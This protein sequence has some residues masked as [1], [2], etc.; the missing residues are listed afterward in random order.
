MQALA[1]EDA[2]LY[3][4]RALTIALLRGE[5]DVAEQATL[6]LALAQA[7]F[8]LSDEERSRRAAHACADAAR[9]A[10]SA[11]SAD[12]AQAAILLWL[13]RTFSGGTDA[14][15]E[16]LPLVREALDAI[17][18][19]L[20][21]TR[22]ELLDVLAFSW[23]SASDAS[24]RANVAYS[25]ESLVLARATGDRRL[26]ADSLCRASLRAERSG[27][28]RGLSRHGRRAQRARHHRLPGSNPELGRVFC[29]PHEGRD[30]RRRPRGVPHDHRRDTR[31]AARRSANPEMGYYVLTW[32]ALGH[33]L[34]GRWSDSEARSI[35][36]VN[37][38]AGFDQAFALQSHFVQLIPIKTAQGRLDEL[39]PLLAAYVEANPLI[40]VYSCGLAHLHTRLDRV[41][42]AHERVAWI[43][44]EGL[45]TIDRYT[46]L[47]LVAMAQA[48][49]TCAATDD[50]PRAETLYGRM[51]DV[52]NVN[53]VVG[54]SGCDGAFDRVLGRLAGLVG[55]WDDAEMHFA[56]AR[57]L[58]QRLQSPPLVARTDVHHAEML[59]RAGRTGDATRA[60]RLLSRAHSTAT[61]L[62]MHEVLQ[63]IEGLRNQ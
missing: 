49:D 30:S 57:A 40:P 46:D 44:D 28:D 18:D 29:S 54:F 8:S 7:Y 36:A 14:A 47:W 12:L 16:E 17:G 38:L 1:F 55:K 26:L 37:T 9:A 59:L 33:R 51:A 39:E 13:L 2:V 58:E 27:H 22:I 60:D 41:A 25:A 45:E 52:T 34:A 10:G 50:A 4:E 53:I 21:A 11:G 20:D 3:L 19:D 42:E 62:E 31:A 24:H 43:V 61:R 35:D 63:D 32:E 15:T 23:Y 5:P 48:A 6:Q 56:T